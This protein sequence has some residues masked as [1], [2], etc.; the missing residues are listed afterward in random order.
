MTTTTPEQRL[1]EAGWTLPSPLATTN[2]FKPTARD[3]ALL[4]VSGHVPKDGERFIHTGRIGV[5]HPTDL[6]HPSRRSF[7]AR[8]PSHSA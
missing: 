1:R 7:P 5:E 3:G 8:R 2:L 6:A 4:Y